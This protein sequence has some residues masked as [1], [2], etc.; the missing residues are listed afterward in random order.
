MA[1]ISYDEGVIFISRGL[2]LDPS[3]FNQLDVLLR[4][5]LA[6]NLLMHQVRLLQHLGEDLGKRFQTSPTIHQLLN[7]IEDWDISNTRYS[8]EDK[9]VVRN[10]WLNGRIVPGLVTELDKP[11]W[12]TLS[13]EDMYEALDRE[14]TKIH[15]GILSARRTGPNK[16]LSAE[17][18]VEELYAKNDQILHRA[19]AGYGQYA[20]ATNKPSRATG[21]LADFLA[22]KAYIFLGTDKY[23]APIRLTI[24]DLSETHQKLLQDLQ[25]IISA[26][27]SSLVEEQ[28]LENLIDKISQ[29]GI[30]EKVEIVGTDTETGEVFDIP[31]VVTPEEKFLVLEFLKK[32]S[33]KERRQPKLT[34]NVK[35]DS[36]SSEY[37]DAYNGAIDLYDKDTVSDEEL[38]E[39]LNLLK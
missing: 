3:T 6:H 26:P 21:D 19:L 17:A 13:L 28:A 27:N 33:P 37:T 22:K 32:I 34:I 18:E 4:H 38:I 36:H 8:A 2:L 1:A 5:E 30:T 12:E 7:I 9:K 15:K 23:G 14:L 16:D 31:W 20:N 39:L 29:S 11:G 24:S 35:K 10:L 25:N